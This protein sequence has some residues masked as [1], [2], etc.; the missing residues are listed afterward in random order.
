MDR[1]AA[2]DPADAAA[3]ARGV[4]SQVS[5]TPTNIRSLARSH[6]DRAIQ[7]LAGIM[8]SQHS[9]DDAKIRAAIALLD[10]GWGRP[11]QTQDMTVNY[12]AE[13]AFLE[14]IRRVNRGAAHNHDSE[15]N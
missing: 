15:L 6:T 10:R 11:A 7:T 3:V 2:A 14:V 8:D 5:K 1:T 4:G 13:A 12:S 9:S